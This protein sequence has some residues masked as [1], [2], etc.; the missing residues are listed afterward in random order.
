MNIFDS[1]GTIIGAATNTIVTTASAAN[2]L[3]LAVHDV[4][5]TCHMHTS[6]LKVQTE[7]ELLPQ[8]AQLQKD[9]AALSA[10]E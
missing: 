6:I 9:M 4:A 10:P 7:R 8:L 5:A 2:E 1:F 3:A